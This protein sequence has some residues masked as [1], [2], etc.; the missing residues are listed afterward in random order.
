MKKALM[1]RLGE[2]GA[3]LPAEDEPL[4]KKLLKRAVLWILAETGQ[5][6]LPEEL[7]SL[8]VDMAAGEYLFWRKNTGMLEGFDEA[9]AVQ[10]M[11]QGD[12]SITYAVAGGTISPLDALIEALR[13]P[14]GALMNKWRR[15]RW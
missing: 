14:N 4:L 11:S 13:T 3:A 8:A 6:E 7:E 2:L 10:K 9:Y 15:M 5:S 12:T 1:L